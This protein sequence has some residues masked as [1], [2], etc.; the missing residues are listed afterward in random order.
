MGGIDSIYKES[1]MENTESKVKE[2]ISVSLTKRIDGIDRVDPIYD[3]YALLNRWLTDI[4]A[5]AYNDYDI[6]LAAN[7]IFEIQSSIGNNLSLEDFRGRVFLT[8][9]RFPNE[10]EAFKRFLELKDSEAHETVLF[11]V[12]EELEGISN[13][14]LFLC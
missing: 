11:A 7:D 13:G 5:I 3:N 4:M 2:M 1:K 6:N 8:S 14:D 12:K 10:I 9:N